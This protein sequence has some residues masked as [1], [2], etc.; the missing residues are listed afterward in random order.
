GGAVELLQVHRYMPPGSAQITQLLL[1]WRNGRKAAIE[2]LTPIVYQ[3]LHRL[4]GAF[5]RGQCPNHPLQPPALVNEAYLRL[6]GQDSPDWQNRV[7][8]LA[9]AARIMRQVLVDFARRKNAAKRDFGCQVTMDDAIAGRSNSPE[10]VI[11]LNGSLD[12]LAEMDPRR[13]RA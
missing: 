6:L 7:H 1:D 2:E 11:A 4:A 8:F 9:T 5:M 3:E 12:R 13:A 10:D